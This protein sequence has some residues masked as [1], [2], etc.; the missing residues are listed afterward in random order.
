MHGGIGHLLWVLLVLL[1]WLAVLRTTGLTIHHLLLVLVV[2][3]SVR[4]HRLS[5]GWLILV[6][7]CLLVDNVHIG[8]LM[9]VIAVSLSASLSLCKHLHSSATSCCCKR[10]NAQE[11]EQER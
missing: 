5:I 1:D 4:V 10:A 8:V 2:E 3:C 9:A 7:W 6:V 11:K